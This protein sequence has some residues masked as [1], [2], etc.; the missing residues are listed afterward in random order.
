[1]DESAA[2]VEVRSLDEHVK[3]LH[4]RGALTAASQE[5]VLEVYERVSAETTRPV[6]LDFTGL[7]YVNSSGIGLLATLLIRANRQRQRVGAFGLNDYH[8]HLFQ[9]A[10]LDQAMDIYDSEKAALAARDG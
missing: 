6:V 7:E 4:I 1:M 3:A 8:R 9:L 10:R 2:S 5:T